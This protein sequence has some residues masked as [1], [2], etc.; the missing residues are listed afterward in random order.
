MIDTVLSPLSSALHTPA[1]ET[2]I[3]ALKDTPFDTGIDLKL[4]EEPTRITREIEEKYSEYAT[5]YAGVN[6]EVLKHK[7]PGG[8]ISQHGRAVE[9]AGRMDLMDAALKESPNVEKDLGYP[10]LLTPTSQIVG[11]QAVFNVL[12]GERYQ[13]ITQEVMNYVAGNYGRPPG[14]VSKELV[15]KI[16]GDKSP[17]T[18]QGQGTSPIRGLGQSGERARP[19]GKERRGYPPGDTLPHAGQGLSDPQ[20]K[21]RTSPITRLS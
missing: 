19:S 16:M 4:L 10:P 2:M 7:M 21:R 14:P 1:T 3:A 20:G 17:I 5:K 11:A 13:I 8:M 9:E 15:T 18:R 6:A 12:M